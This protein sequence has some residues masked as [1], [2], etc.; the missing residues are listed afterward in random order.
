[1]DLLIDECVP[2]SVTE[3]FANHGHHIQRVVDELGQRTPDKVIARFA[4]NNG[5]VLITWNVRDFYRLG[6]M[7]RP[8]QNQQQYPNAGMI[9]FKC[10]ETQGARR[11]E[12][13][14]E[15]IEFEYRQASQ[16]LDTRLLMEIH[17]DKIVIRY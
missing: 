9:S 13:V 2:E 7:R 15:S 11:A 12:Q 10:E 3:V 17:I 5:L 16:R 6:M 4:D 14:M 1:M 8:P